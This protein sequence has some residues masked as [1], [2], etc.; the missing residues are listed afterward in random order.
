MATDIRLEKSEKLFL[1][2]EKLLKEH[3]GDNGY[4]LIFAYETGEHVSQEIGDLEVDVMFH[5]LTNLNMGSRL[6]TWKGILAAL[7]R[8]MD[9]L[10]REYR[11]PE[12]E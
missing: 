3:L 11:L 8:R 6:I 5:T 1:E 7:S 12:T 10:L 9:E 2:M 4:A